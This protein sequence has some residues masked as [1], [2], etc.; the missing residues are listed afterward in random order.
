MKIIVGSKNPVKFQATG[1]V[2]EKIYGELEVQAIDVDS[3]VPDQPIGLEVTVQGAINRA[4]NAFS[5]DF[6]LSVG[7]ESGLLE[8]PHSITGYLD[9]QWCAIYD[10]EKITLGVSA[11]FEYPPMVIEQVL[12]GREVGD[13]MD[14]VTGVNKLGQKTGA[15]SHLTQGMLDRTGNTEQCVLMAMVPRMNEGV[16]FG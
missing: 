6:D 5:P 3:G 12:G 11:G 9:L 4:K 1:N 8:V 14:Q 13:V 7:I 2:L 15:V 16:Y 10:G